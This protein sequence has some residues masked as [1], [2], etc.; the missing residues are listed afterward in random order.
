MVSSEV[1]WQPGVPFSLAREFLVEIGVPPP[2]SAAW[3]NRYSC[4]RVPRQLSPVQ[5]KPVEQAIQMVVAIT[6]SEAPPDK[7]SDK[8]YRPNIR[9]ESVRLGSA[10]QQAR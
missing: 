1:Y 5:A 9:G 4:G 8:R 10:R 7:L 6:N 2:Q 3:P